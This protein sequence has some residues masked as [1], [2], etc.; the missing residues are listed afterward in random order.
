MTRKP[1]QTPAH[2]RKALANAAGFP[3]IAKRIGN[4]AT[5]LLVT[6][7]I[8]IVGIAFG[9][10][11]VSWWRGDS[12]ANDVSP[13][14]AVV[15]DHVPPAT[16]ARQLLEFGDCPFVLNRQ[17]FVGDVTKVLEQLRAASR[18]AIDSSE[19]LARDFGPAE[20]RMLDAANRLVPVEEQANRWSIYQ[21]EVPLPMVLGVRSS[22]PHVATPD[23][24]VVSWGLAVPEATPAGEPQSEWTLFTYSSD[25]TA[26]TTPERLI[27][28]APPGGRRTLSLRTDRGG[29][30]VGYAGIGTVESWTRFYD[31]LFAAASPRR[32]NDW[33][34]DF[35]SWRRRFV[36]AG[37]EVVDVVIHLDG[38]ETIRS[39]VITSPNHRLGD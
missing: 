10:E 12:S 19:P 24:R 1:Q 2:D 9:R 36:S 30:M 22:D 26:E 16:A 3:S 38:E 31:E 27:R 11:V 14:A 18:K 39:L 4:L 33:Q 32:G 8:V 13:L 35:G 29:N 5:N 34:V 6:G 21:I 23:R 15:G 25:A 20:Q 28:P 37:D 7:V 17:E